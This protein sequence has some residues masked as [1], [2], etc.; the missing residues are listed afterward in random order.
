VHHGAAHD[1]VVTHVPTARGGGAAP[2]ARDTD[3]RSG[4]GMG[5]KLAWMLL[6][7]GVGAATTWLADPQLGTARRAELQNQARKLL[8]RSTEQA[9]DVVRD[10]A[11]RAMGSAIDAIPEVTDAPD[12][13]VLERVR[14]EAIGQVEVP[15]SQIV[16]NVHD[17]VVELRGQVDSLPQRETLLEA[18][19]DVDGV[20]DIVDLT[21]LPGEPAPTRS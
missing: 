3:E 11:Q 14:S 13:V 21:H 4:A 2:G 19:R 17:G 16:T 15:T 9:S 1:H 5:A 12:A 20:R 10:A 18:V 6:G 7:A 8:R